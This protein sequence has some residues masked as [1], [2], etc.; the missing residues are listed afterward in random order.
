VEEHS[1]DTH[2]LAPKA[3]VERW[4]AIINGD[5]PSVKWTEGGAEEVMS[6]DVRWR[7]IGSTPIS[8]LHHGFGELRPGFWSMLYEGDGRGSGT[9]G[10]DRDYDRKLRADAI[11]EIE[12]GRV[13]LLAQ[14]DAR[15]RN[16]KP[17]DNEYCFLIRVADGKIA[18][19]TEYCDTAMIERVIFDKAI[20]PAEKLRAD[21]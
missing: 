2:A 3:V 14:A 11:L 21:S 4:L 8:R 6:P 15:G 7:L 1:P 18:E 5:T 9:Q 10:L 17:Y 19:M 20:V 16:G 12:D 13:L